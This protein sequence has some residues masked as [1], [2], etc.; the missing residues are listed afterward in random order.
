MRVTT[1]GQTQ[2]IIARLLDTS[3][4]LADASDQVTSGLKVSKMSDDPTS[5]SLIVRDNA[6]LRGIDQYTRNATSTGT[7][8]DAE[9]TV[10]QQ[11]ND[12]LN[13]AKQLGVGANSATTTPSERAA[14]AAE[15]QQLLAQ[16]VSLGN[17][18]VGNTYL[19]GG[20]TNDG[21]EPFDPSQPAFVPTDPATTAGGTPTPHYPVGQLSIDVG[22][23][24]QTVTGAHDGTS[25]FLGTTNGAPDSTK[26]VLP[27]LQQLQQ[28]L[29]GSDPSKIGAA[30]TSLDTAFDTLQVHIGELGAR[31]NQVDAVKTGLT[32]LQS[33]VT[34]QQ[35]DL[36]DV[37][38]AQAYTEMV[39]RQTAYQA[40]MMASSKVM[41]LSLTD[42][43][44]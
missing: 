2:A 16:A 28:A 32:G 22:A 33:S 44:K 8:L 7:A 25:I 10:T 12:L 37:D 42:Y 14:S 17:T 41:G 20:T 43:L 15:V 21:R 18:K 13:R 38:T 1:A 35:S 39:A 23:G 30:L 11:L 6:T 27:A 29:A 34:Q 31:Q 3:S 4:K 36:R 5:A 19:F 40:A 26:G 24:G 9:D